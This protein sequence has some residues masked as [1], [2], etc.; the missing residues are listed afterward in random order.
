[1]P[2]TPLEAATVSAFV[3]AHPAWSFDGK[4]LRCCYALKGFAAPLAAAVKL[5]LLAEKHDHH[6]DLEIGWGRLAV[7]WTTHDAGG[8]TQSDL[9]MA[10]ATDTIV[11]AEKAQ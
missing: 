10:E 2:R 11:G 4:A 8:V 1:M 5:G 7:V 6:P 9:D 3:A